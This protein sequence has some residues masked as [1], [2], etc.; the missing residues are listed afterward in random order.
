MIIRQA[1]S[2][3][4]SISSCLFLLFIFLGFVYSTVSCFTFQRI[5]RTM[6]PSKIPSITNGVNGH[7]LWADYPDTEPQTGPYRVLEQYHSKRTRLRVA[8]IGAGASGNEP[9]SL[10][11]N[12]AEQVRTMSCLQDGEDVAAGYVGPDTIRKEPAPWRDMV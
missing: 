4:S 5:F 10:H 7:D 9:K 1:L 12:A 6:S 3:H 2:S 11:E 8:S